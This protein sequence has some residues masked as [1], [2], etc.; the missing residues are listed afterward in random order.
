VCRPRRGDW[1]ATVALKAAY[2]LVP[3]NIAV[4][5][6]KKPPIASG[7]DPAEPEAAPLYTSDFVPYKPQADILVVG[8]AHSPSSKP[9]GSCRVSIAIGKHRKS[10]AVFGD[11]RWTL[12]RF[13]AH[14]GDP[15]PFVTMPLGYERAFGGPNYRRNPVGCGADL[16]SG[17]PLPN[18]ERLDQLI[19]Q[20]LDRPDPAGF[21]PLAMTWQSRIGKAG[22]YDATWQ[23]TR[24]PWFP[25]DLDWSFF[26]AA[27]ADQQF[28]F[29]RGD[30]AL[31]FEN[32]HPEHALYRTRLPGVA[33]RIFVARTAMDG[34]ERFEEIRSHLDTVW[35]D[36][37]AERLVLVWRGVT[38]VDSQRLREI[39]AIFTTLE[40]LASCAETEAH[41]ALFTA[42]RDAQTRS[43]DADMAAAECAEIDRARQT[44][45]PRVADARALAASLRQIADGML[46]AMGVDL[47]ARRAR[48]ASQDPMAALEQALATLKEAD[49]AKG[50]RLQQRLDEADRRVGEA[51]SKVGET[52]GRVGEAIGQPPWS[53][54]R[55][56]TAL[57]AGKSLA[58]ARLD[59]LDLTEIDFAG[60]DLQEATLTGASLRNARFERANLA[61]ADLRK[62]DLS[63]ADFT[64]ADLS[65]T[66]LREATVQGARFTGARLDGAVFA[67]LDLTGADF[68]D[69]I[70]TAVDFTEAILDGA[71]FA[72]ASMP[73]GRFSAVHA[74]G[75]DFTEAILAAAT[76]AGAKAAGIFMEGA[77]LTNLRAGR[78][79][80]FS[81]GRFARAHAPR[82]VWQQAVLD[83]ADFSRA[84]LSQ[85]QFLE[86][87]LAMAVFDRAHLPGTNFEDALLPDA[88][89][90]NAN[91]LRASFERADLTRA[92]VDGSNLYGAGLL[93]ATLDD[94]TFRGSFVAQTLLAK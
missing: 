43:G 91:L 30:E 56:E 75:T 53:P 59:G 21:G 71:R 29:F 57:A 20:S 47:G 3:D 79:A 90:T 52:I 35:V 51:M 24:W 28:P 63:D 65:R 49:P 26:N 66:N 5:D 38:R 8:A 19:T 50:A 80:D 6:E 89:L 37:G 60:A 31:A 61:G 70:G 42:L 13:G 48:L 84:M 86:A 39:A 11:R 58:K 44:V 87:S 23:K 1:R 40:P 81:E 77:D 10:L 34:E 9:V 46:K 22:T 62:R 68:T 92:R 7:D 45:E 74:A 85:A 15:V 27:P 83:R 64:V 72:N 93:D 36:V 41:R 2:R 73:R 25:A 54:E 18:I 94:A 32:L 14:P 82:S 16:R 69:A 78:G 55:I 4:P 88:R 76:F 33:A 17:Q 12:S 67:N